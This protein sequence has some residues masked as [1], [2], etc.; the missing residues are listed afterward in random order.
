MVGLGDDNGHGLNFLTEAM[1]EDPAGQ[2][3]LCQHIEDVVEIIKSLEDDLR[4]NGQKAIVIIA[5]D[6]EASDGE[7]ARALK[8]LESLPVLLI[9]RLCT[10]ESEVVRYWDEVDRQLE[11]EM[12]VLDDLAAGNSNS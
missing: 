4:R 9:L 1:E 3:P 10:D 12:D 8:P 6:G 5:T 11:L 2:T 7:V